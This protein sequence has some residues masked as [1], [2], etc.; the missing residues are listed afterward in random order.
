MQSRSRVRARRRSLGQTGQ[1]VSGQSK[2]V[3]MSIP[4]GG[5]S[6]G[7]SS[8]DIAT[9]RNTRPSQI[10]EVEVGVRLLAGQYRI[11]VLAADEAH[12]PV[13]RMLSPALCVCR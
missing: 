13:V 8:S 2:T 10:V 7:T 3:V 11:A 12:L 1:A 4:A 6:G 5:S 9:M